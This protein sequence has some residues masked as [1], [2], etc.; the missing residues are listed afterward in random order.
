[1]LRTI[2]ALALIL[3]ASPASARFDCGRTQCAHFGIHHCG[4][5][6]LALEWAHRFPHTSAHPG[7]VVVQR[8]KGRALG[9]GPGG[10]VSRIVSLRGECRA[11]VADDRGHY[12][13][14]ICSRLVAYVEP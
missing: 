2:A 9:G 4:P 13:R 12:E 7:A 3:A 5:L 14:D 6:A 10:H 8:R 1:M 11:I